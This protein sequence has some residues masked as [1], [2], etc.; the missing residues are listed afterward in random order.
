MKAQNG[1]EVSEVR[2]GILGVKEC[3]KQMGGGV[4]RTPTQS[5]KGYR[6]VREA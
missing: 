4:V 5:G 2:E 3:P 6:K 1:R